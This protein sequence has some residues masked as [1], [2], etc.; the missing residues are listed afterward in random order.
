MLRGNAW[1]RFGLEL[2]RLGRADAN[3][4]REPRVLQMA[5]QDGTRVAG[6]PLGVERLLGGTRGRE[7]R[8]QAGPSP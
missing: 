1:V 4:Q 3:R 6:K 2:P 7:Q 5:W 8:A